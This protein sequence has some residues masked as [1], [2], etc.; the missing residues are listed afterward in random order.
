MEKLS[1]AYTWPHFAD[2]DSCVAVPVC[3][4]ECVLCVG[5]L[6]SRFHCDDKWCSAVLLFL[7]KTSN[8]C[9]T[10]NQS[11]N[12]SIPTDAAINWANI[13]LNDLVNSQL[14][15]VCPLNPLGVGSSI[16]NGLCSGA[17]D[18]AILFSKVCKLI[19]KWR[20]ETVY[21]Y[22]LRN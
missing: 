21:L 14:L 11:I 18:V 10:V 19:E 12:Q 20:E 2:S 9:P 17:H 3:V 6:S 8:Y 22:L 1:T 5:V 13:L 16:H 15:L 4:C 7:R